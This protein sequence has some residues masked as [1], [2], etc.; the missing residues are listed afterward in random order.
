MPT[1]GK[2]VAAIA[3][4][5]LAYFITDLVKPLLPEGTRL[6]LFSP[7]NALIGMAMGW[8]I[9]G[10]G[11]GRSYWASLGYGLTTLAATVFWC[12]VC[13]AGYE[14]LKRSLRLYYDGPV[15]ALQEMAQ[16]AIDNVRL[17]MV[18]EVY[19]PALVGTIFVTW[20]AEYFG[21]RWS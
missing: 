10:K 15:E 9:L 20:L 21:R 1:G 11:V 5:A 7:I 8:T 19:W 3:F 13:W 6:G 16:L 14:M 18:P 4:A 2:L 17:I 12:V